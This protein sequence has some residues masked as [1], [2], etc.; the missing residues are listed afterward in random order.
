[1][2]IGDEK[3]VPDIR[4]PSYEA[5]LL[6]IQS[7]CAALDRAGVD[8]CDDPGEAI[9]VMR[10]GYE[11]RLAAHQPPAEAQAQGGWEA[12][13]EVCEDQSGSKYLCWSPGLTPLPPAGTRLYTAPPS[14]HVVVEHV[15]AALQKW[16]DWCNEHNE[17]P[18]ARSGARIAIEALAHPAITH[19]DNCGFDWLDNGLNPVG[20]PYCKQPVGV[21][22]F[23]TA[24][25]KARRVWM[26]ENP[27]E[28]G[29]DHVTPFDQFLYGPL[30]QQPAAVDEKYAELIY[31][32]ANKYPDESRHE[33]ALRY[34]RQAESVDH[35]DAQAA[36]Q[37]GGAE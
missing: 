25:E 30:A 20:C 19:C 13:A 21:E 14:A 18:E 31:A 22:G 37:P 6:I 35:G 15:E 5:C 1:M 24:V 4:S 29:H 10:D 2:T 3:V 36:T 8:D 23:R 28:D 7:V 34:I 16:L 33:T 12:V 32:V 26:D 17:E 9:D 27:C 11:R